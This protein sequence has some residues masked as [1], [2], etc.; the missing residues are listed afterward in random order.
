MLRVYAAWTGRLQFSVFALNEIYPALDS[1]Y[2]LWSG[3]PITKNL[4]TNYT[5]FWIRRVRTPKNNAKR[6][7]FTLIF[8]LICCAKQYWFIANWYLQNY[9]RSR[10][11]V[12]SFIRTQS[13][14]SRPLLKSGGFKV[15]YLPKYFSDWEMQHVIRI[16]SPRPIF[17]EKIKILSYAL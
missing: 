12:T 1:L 7:Y 16:V 6:R 11:D 2:R 17:S 14:F 15:K 3:I 5:A 4:M 9:F 10:F 8:V 13:Y